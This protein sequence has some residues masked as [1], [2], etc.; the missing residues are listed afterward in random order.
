MPTPSE[1]VAMVTV[2]MLSDEPATYI[3]PYNQITTSKM[4]TKVTAACLGERNPMESEAKTNT[5]PRMREDCISSCMAVD[6]VKR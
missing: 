2:T 3:K 1:M 6:A 4:G 5:E